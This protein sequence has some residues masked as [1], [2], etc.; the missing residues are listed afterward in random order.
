M[1]ETLLYIII[2]FVAANFVIAALYLLRM[3]K[4]GS[5][6][7]EAALREEFRLAR[8]ESSQQSSELRKEVGKI[9]T[10]S[11]KLLIETVNTMDSKQGERLDK[12]TAAIGQSV[13]ATCE[14]IAKL[15]ERAEGSLKD[16]RESNENR[17]E[18]IRVSVNEQLAEM[19]SKEERK[20]GEVGDSLNKLSR[21]NRED[22]EK[23]RKTLETQFQRIQESNEKRLDAM[24]R[25]VDE[26]LQSTLERR[27]GESFRL[28]SKQLEAVHKGLGDMQKLATGVGDLKR[29]LT[30]V[31]ARGTWGEVQLGAL[32]EQILTRGQYVANVRPRPDSNETVEYAI[33]LPG[34]GDGSIWLP[35]DAKFPTA[36]YERLQEAA[37]SG[38]ADQVSRASHALIR[39]IETSAADV[40]TKYVAPPQTTDFAIMFLPT[41][42]LYAEVARRPEVLERLQ[43]VHRV[44]PAGPATLAAILNSL[45]M[46]FRTLA[47][48]KRSSEVWKVLSAVKTEFGKFGIVLDKVKKQLDTASRSIDQTGTRTRAIERK[49]NT[50][51]EL[52][53]NEDAGV[54]LGLT[55]AEGRNSEG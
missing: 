34:V 26:K 50:V 40:R 48:E 6:R 2:L 52:P 18:K 27:L 4:P 25:T 28:V 30:N 43:R 7:T 8:G 38:N 41:E 51:E 31:K 33:R 23:A 54:L 1:T 13:S 24:R 14:Q 15:I 19:M 39:A 53:I 49:L 3:R 21:L 22:Q 37:E 47:I 11:N 5:D 46:G 32:L 20:L 44:V 36:D 12:L 45:Q 16:I 9:Q 29:V 10:Q 42:G 55:Q 17:F 35:I